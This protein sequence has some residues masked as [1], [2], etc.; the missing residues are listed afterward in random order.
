MM[1]GN[2]SVLSPGVG[3]PS[4]RSTDSR[5][6]DLTGGGTS[7]AA[8]NLSAYLALVMQRWP[9]ATGNQILQ[10]LIRNTKGNASGGPKLDPEHKRGFGI[11]DP[12]KLLSVDP[13]RYPDV[14]PLL[15]WAVKTSGE[16]EETKGMYEYP[17]PLGGME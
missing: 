5:E 10:S 4:Y 9:D 11:V 6:M 16:H 14:N 13:T 15:E 12:G 1:D 2:V 17:S 3:V 8:A 7:T